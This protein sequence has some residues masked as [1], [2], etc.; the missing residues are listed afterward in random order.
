MHG[1]GKPRVE[2]DSRV[3]CFFIKQVVRLFF[4]VKK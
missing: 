4:G 3:A 1:D 2:K